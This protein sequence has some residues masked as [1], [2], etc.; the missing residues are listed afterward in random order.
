METK[1]LGPVDPGEDLYFSF[2]D[3]EGIVKIDRL[4]RPDGNVGD[5]ITIH[6]ARACDRDAKTIVAGL[7]AFEPEEFLAI[8][9]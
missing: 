1:Q 2:I 9:S 4:I 7:V 5:A 8:G 6:V 3:E